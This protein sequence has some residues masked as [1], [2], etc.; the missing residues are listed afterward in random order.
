MNPKVWWHA[1]PGCH[2]QHGGDEIF[3]FFS[4]GW[5]SIVSLYPSGCHHVSA[6]TRRGA[7]SSKN[8]WMLAQNHASCW[9]SWPNVCLGCDI[10]M[11]WHQPAVVVVELN[12]TPWFQVR[13]R[14]RQFRYLQVTDRQFRCLG[15]RARWVAT[16]RVSLVSFD[17]FVLSQ[18]LELRQ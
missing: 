1:I 12:F 9:T 17:G 6:V 14:Q 13:G 15:P 7:N 18:I 2:F 16:Y 8:W 5:Y 10:N 3:S 11:L 4:I